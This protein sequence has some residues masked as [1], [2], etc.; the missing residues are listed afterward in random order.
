MSTGA[1]HLS[2]FTL[3]ALALGALAPGE[4]A[5][6]R[7]HLSSCDACGREL[8]AAQTAREEFHKSVMPRT[9]ARVHERAGRRRWWTVLNKWAL[10][11]VPALAAAA[12][13]VVLLRGG[14]PSVGPGDDAVL[15]TK[16]SATLRVF[17]NHEG[18]VFQLRDGSLLAPGDQIRFVVEPGD[19]P[20]LLVASVD[21]TGKASV[22]YPFEAAESGR[23]D[24]AI[25]LELP[26]SIVLD[27]A[28]GPER[29][30]ALFSREPVNAT[31]VRAALAALGRL[32]PDAIRSQRTLHVPVQSQ[33]SLFFEKVIP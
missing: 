2:S 9:L 23:L 22:Y 19:L 16:G 21:G 30:F 28:P 31:I 17:A 6:A 20:Y 8:K 4:E 3:D 12:L 25:T 10:L 18:R 24:K 1:E 15:A 5:Q 32:G 26:G 29:I 27:A 11:P 7:Q 33:V 13:L 14:A